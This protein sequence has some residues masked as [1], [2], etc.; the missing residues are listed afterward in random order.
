MNILVS[1]GHFGLGHVRAAH[2][3]KASLENQHRDIQV[4][5]VDLFEYLAPKTSKK[6]YALFN[7]WTRYTPR[8]YNRLNAISCHVNS[9]PLDRGTFKKIET[10]LI[11]YQAD[12]VIS[13]L[14]YCTKCI[15][16]Y[17]TMTRSQL[18]L[19]SY[20]TDIVA[21]EEWI[22]PDVDTY[23]VASA[24]TKKWI[25]SYGVVPEKVRV[26]GMPYI[27]Q[28]RDTLASSCG[29]QQDLAQ[30]C[31]DRVELLIMGGGLGLIPLEAACYD[32]LAQADDV[33]VTVVTGKNH[34]LYERLV[35]AYPN[36]EVVGFTQEVERYVQR[37]S[38]IVSKPGG[39]TTFEAICAQTPLLSLKPFLAQE[40][41]NATFIQ[42]EHIGLVAH[43]RGETLACEALSLVR[44]E[45]AL[46]RYQQSMA[47][48]CAA[49]EKEQFHIAESLRVILR[50]NKEASACA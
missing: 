26:C 11:A 49:W 36:F 33:H 14:P 8:L 32:I 17:K 3:I 28:D 12:M 18:P 46:K 40:I 38:L 20:V 48:L 39:I 43:G 1:T 45:L 25:V 37:A 23:F 22:S 41:G 2:A 9:L 7:F 31:S 30:S 27:K 21:H 35:T 29:G 16:A 6:F 13:T 50:A 4:E 44:D 47:R 5:V 24:M 10:L 34:K 19:Y 42:A 15:G